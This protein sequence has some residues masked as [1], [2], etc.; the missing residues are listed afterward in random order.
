MRK[1]HWIRGIGVVVLTA[2][3]AFASDR[4]EVDP[5]HATIGFEVSHLVI[6]KVRG[7]FKEYSASLLLDEDGTL[8]EAEA[9]IQT[10]SID[11]G[12]KKRDNHL[13]NADFFDVSTYPEIMFKS[14]SIEE[15]NGA[16][17][18]IG[19]LTIRGVSKQIE[20]PYKLLGPIKDPWGNTKIGL[21][22]STTIDRTEFGLTWNKALEAGGV[23]VGDE[24][25]LQINLE[26]A[27]Q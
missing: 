13:R 2:G 11:T 10:Q 4:Y 25:E 15:K 3:M 17:L 18:M 16:T 24:V 7:H 1:M 26:A 5:T 14:T 6:S 12:V 20:L 21:E 23:V 8:L 9:V 22:A 19:D 27:K